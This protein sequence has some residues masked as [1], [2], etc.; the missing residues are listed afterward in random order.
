MLCVELKK[1]DSLG[2][3]TKLEGPEKR[4]R[5]EMRWSMRQGDVDKDILRF[6]VM[7][8]YDGMESRQQ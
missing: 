7:K 6:T 8:A 4:R 1:N 5:G 3:K 2:R